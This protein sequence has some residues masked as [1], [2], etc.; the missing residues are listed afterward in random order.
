[1]VTKTNEKMDPN[2]PRPPSKINEVEL[3]GLK[4]MES[5]YRSMR[6]IGFVFKSVVE[7]PSHPK[8]NVPVGGN[9]A[10]RDKKFLIVGFSNYYL[11]RIDNGFM[12]EKKL[13]D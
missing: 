2:L 12:G 3:I 8:P 11:H 6:T 1:M 13:C 10:E 7:K 9:P 5:G 4:E